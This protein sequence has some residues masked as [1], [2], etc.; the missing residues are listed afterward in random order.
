MAWCGL[1]LSLQALQQAATTAQ[2][3]VKEAHRE[4]EQ[5]EEPRGHQVSPGDLV[6]VKRHQ[7]G[8]LEPL[9]DG[10]YTVVLTTPSAVKVA[11]KK[12]WIH[13]TQVKEDRTMGCSS[14]S[15]DHRREPKPRGG[16]GT[17]T[18]TTEM[19]CSPRTYNEGGHLLFARGLFPAPEQQFSQP[20]SCLGNSDQDVQ[21]VS[22]NQ[23][24]PGLCPWGHRRRGL[25]LGDISGTGLCVA[26]ANY[27]LGDSPYQGN[28]SQTPRGEL[29][30]GGSPGTW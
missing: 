18:I 3:I 8:G 12:H 5:Q 27:S 25:T 20:D 21:N 16:A 13:L 7:P 24:T 2:R 10:P 15:R 19:A 11:G 30:R 23:E 28:C 4:T 6:W 29:G 26:S 22:T 9:W 14:R 1:C 17:G